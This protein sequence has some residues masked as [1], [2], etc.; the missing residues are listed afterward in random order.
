M[1][2][3]SR[4][5]SCGSQTG[6]QQ[7]QNWWAA[8]QNRGCGTNTQDCTIEWGPPPAPGEAQ[9]FSFPVYKPVMCYQRYDIEYTIT[10]GQLMVPQW[11]CP[12]G[13]TTTPTPDP[14]RPNI[15]ED[16]FFPPWDPRASD[17]NG[18]R[19]IQPQS[20]SSLVTNQAVLTAFGLQ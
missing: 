3:S 16:A 18:N 11:A 1:T 10:P 4:I 17:F 15:P 2:C 12:P 9:S 19:L 6:M 20:T 5:G 7:Q 13:T 8:Q 14:I